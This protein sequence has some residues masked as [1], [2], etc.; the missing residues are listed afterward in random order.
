LIIKCKKEEEE[1]EEEEE[2]EEEEQNVLRITL[3]QLL[4]RTISNWIFTDILFTITKT[5]IYVLM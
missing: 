1:E 5:L 4:Y 3:Y 2:K